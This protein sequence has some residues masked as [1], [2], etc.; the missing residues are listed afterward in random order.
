MPLQRKKCVAVLL[1]TLAGQIALHLVYGEET[2]LYGL[3]FVPLLIALAAL[4]TTTKAGKLAPWAALAL[5]GFAL[6]NNLSVFNDAAAHV[7]G[8]LTQNE[9]ARRVMRERP[10]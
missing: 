4:S 8:S 3:H 10:A 2:F 5:A 9:Q 1:L 6:A 7:M